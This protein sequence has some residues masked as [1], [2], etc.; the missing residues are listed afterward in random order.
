MSGTKNDQG[1]L[2]WD[3]L[4]FGSVREIVKVLTYGARKYSPDN[5]KSVPNPRN[6][7][8][9]ATMRHLDAWWEGEKVDDETG[10]SHL[11]HAGCCLLF[12]L[13]F[14][15]KITGECQMERMFD[16][17]AGGD[18]LDNHLSGEYAFGKETNIYTKF[19]PGDT[20]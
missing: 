6:R 11:A 8:F 19:E 13:Y 14:E 3:L 2:R 1:K 5:W 16:E 12:L 4:P 18:F 9:A 10:Y 7:Y 17:L 20:L 15:K